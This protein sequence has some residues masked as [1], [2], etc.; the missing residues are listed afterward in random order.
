MRLSVLSALIAVSTVWS[1]SSASAEYACIGM[2]PAMF[3]LRSDGV[4]G[5]SYSLESGWNGMFDADPR[6]PC[7]DPT[8]VV[9]NMCEAFLS[10]Q[11]RVHSEVDQKSTVG[12]LTAQLEE[13]NRQLDSQGAEILRL[14][15]E[16]K[17]LRS[18][19]RQRR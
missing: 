19:L 9:V 10:T 1:V 13:Q 15:K 3:A 18:R 12:L 16:N 5:S 11:G 6:G 7:F 4:M 17:R 14:V 8:P 2:S